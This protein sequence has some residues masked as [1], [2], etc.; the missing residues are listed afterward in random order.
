MKACEKW[1]KRFN[2][3]HRGNMSYTPNFDQG[4]RAALEW[5]KK[6]MDEI[7]NKDIGISGQEVIENELEEE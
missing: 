2:V 5:F 4:W 6:T 1:K 3:T 7:E